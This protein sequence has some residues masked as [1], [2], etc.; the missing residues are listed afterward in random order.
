MPLTAENITERIKTAFNIRSG[1]K[2]WKGLFRKAEETAQ[3]LIVDL[4]AS[5]N[6]IQQLHEEASTRD[7]Y[8]RKAD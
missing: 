6:D 1:L 5:H 2:E 4:V 7:A 8:L 3:G